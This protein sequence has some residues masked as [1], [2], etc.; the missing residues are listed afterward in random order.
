MNVARQGFTLVELL[1][2]LA[3]MI[4][5]L[6]LGAAASGQWGRP[7]RMRRAE[8]ETKS[9]LD[10]ARQWAVT[11]QTRTVFYD[12][13]DSDG[14]ALYWMEAH[15]H[16]GTIGI[17]NML[18]AGIVWSNNWPVIAFQ[19]DGTLEGDSD[20]DIVIAERADRPRPLVSTVRVY[21]VTGQAVV[22]TGGEP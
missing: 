3:I 11:H 20:R 1:A 21:R 13:N 8:R 12:E 4:V 6:S 19:P 9:A 2:C 7:A 18:P 17:T 22:L 10:T 14:R 16:G 15:R 5:L